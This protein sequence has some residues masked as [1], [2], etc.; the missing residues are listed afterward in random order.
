MLLVHW[1]CLDVADYDLNQLMLWQAYLANAGLAIVSFF[2]LVF[3][4]KTAGG[5]LVYIFFAYSFAKVAVF[6]LGFRPVY[7]ADDQVTKIEF[8]SFFVPYFVAL[9]AEIVALSRI[10]KEQDNARK[11]NTLKK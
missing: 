4:S 11:E 7:L 6:L 1:F 2:L 3:M 8:L 9:V 5:T 10:L